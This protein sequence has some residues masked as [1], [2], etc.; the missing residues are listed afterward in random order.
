MD[1]PKQWTT[2]RIDCPEDRGTGGLLLEWT[3]KEG[4]PVLTGVHCDNPHLKDL[5]GGDCGWSCWDRLEI[6]P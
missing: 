4:K 2:C 5:G 1:R 6:A 3:E